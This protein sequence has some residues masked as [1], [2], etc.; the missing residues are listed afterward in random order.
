MMEI[1]QDKGRIPALQAAVCM[2]AALLLSC[3]GGGGSQAPEEEQEP[4]AAS[5]RV[6][7]AQAQVDAQSQPLPAEDPSP[8]ELL[9]PDGA[10]VSVVVGEPVDLELEAESSDGVAALR[11]RL[12]GEEEEVE[13]ENPTDSGTPGGEGKSLQNRRRFRLTLVVLWLEMPLAGWDCL[14]F[15]VRDHQGRVSPYVPVCFEV[16]EAAI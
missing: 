3:G 13:V 16:A 7:I 10:V 5:A 2:A 1:R 14:D 11:V 12:G 15:A 4:P 9:S 6:S 8:P